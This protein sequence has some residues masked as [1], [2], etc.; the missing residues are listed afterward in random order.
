M[1]QR[2]HFTKRKLESFFSLIRQYRLQSCL[3]KNLIFSNTY[4]S[5]MVNIL[6]VLYK[7]ESYS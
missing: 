5:P 6:N 4:L 2:E 7:N 3:F 1:G